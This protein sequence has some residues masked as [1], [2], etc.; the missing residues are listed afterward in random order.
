VA[1]TL[2]IETKSSCSLNSQCKDTT[3]ELDFSFFP[4]AADL[5]LEQP[6]LCEPVLMAH[7]NAQD[8]TPPFAYRWFLNGAEIT[9]DDPTYATSDTIVIPLDPDVCDDT[10]VAVIVEDT[11]CSVEDSDIIDVNQKPVAQFAEAR[12]GDCDLTLTYDGTASTDCNVGDTL[13]YLWDFDGDGRPDSSE[14]AGT[15]VYPVCG[16]RTIGFIALDEAA[17]PSDAAQMR[18]Y[19]NQPPMAGLR[20]QGGDCLNLLFADTTVDCDLTQNSDLYT[21][22]LDTLIDFGDGTNT[23]ENLGT[24]EYPTCGSYPVNLTS[25]D[26]KG[27]TDSVDRSVTIETVF[28]ID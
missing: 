12:V 4:L 15:H 1:A 27:C 3:G 21:E 28:Q 2:E 23:T 26:A 19:A 16:E 10:E 18:V 24:H 9:D 25:T 6:D 14:P 20:L 5:A 11:H 7:A 13:S 17:C 22:S 8:G